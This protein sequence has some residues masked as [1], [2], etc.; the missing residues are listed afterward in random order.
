MASPH[1]K[2]DIIFSEDDDQKKWDDLIEHC[3]SNLEEDA[4]L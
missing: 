3:L 2:D 1:I 4:L